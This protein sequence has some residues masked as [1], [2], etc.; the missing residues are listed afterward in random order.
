MVILG[1]RKERDVNGARAN[2]QAQGYLVTNVRRIHHP[3]YRVTLHLMVTELGLIPEGR[4]IFN[5]QTIPADSQ[6]NVE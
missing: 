4:A 2:I 3:M 5:I 1:I 6:I